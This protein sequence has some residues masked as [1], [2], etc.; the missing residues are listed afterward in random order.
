MGRDDEFADFV[1]TRWTRFVKS[2]VLLGCSR[3]E[4]EDLA[5][6][7]MVRCYVAWPKVRVAADRDAYAYRILLNCHRDNRRRHWW[8][9]RPTD[10]LPETAI[11]DATGSSDVSL[12]VE[13][14]LSR[15]STPAREA[16]VLRY[17]AQLSEQEMARVLGIAPGTVKSRLS[18]ALAELSR[19]S[20]L[21]DRNEGSTT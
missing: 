12:D 3:A 19:D 14:A 21:A 7:A 13:R 17:Y 16:V 20:H 2:A 8:G 1:A 18:R 10:R 15:L 4:A 6:T 5:Q 11:P 9:E